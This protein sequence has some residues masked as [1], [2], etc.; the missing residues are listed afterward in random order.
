MDAWG[1]VRARLLSYLRA[2]RGRCR[3]P[4]RLPDRP[5]DPVRP[6]GNP[7]GQTPMEF[8][9]RLV[10][11]P[12]AG[13]ETQGA[14]PRVFKR[15]AL[16]P[17]LRPLRPGQPQRAPQPSK[18]PD[19]RPSRLLP[20]DPTPAVSI[21]TE[22]GAYEE[23]ECD[24]PFRANK[25]TA[26]SSQPPD[27]NSNQVRKALLPPPLKPQL[28]SPAPSPARKRSTFDPGAPPS[29]SPPRHPDYSVPL[30]GAADRPLGSNQ[31]TDAEY[32]YT[33]PEGTGRTLPCPETPALGGLKS[34][35]STRG[36][37]PPPPPPPPPPPLPAR[38]SFMTRIPLYLPVLP[39]LPDK[40]TSATA[41]TGPPDKEQLPGNP[42]VILV[43]VGRLVAQDDDDD[44]DDGVLLVP[45][46][47]I[48]C[49]GCGAASEA[50]YYD[51]TVGPCCP[52]CTA[53]DP[54]WRPAPCLPHPQGPEH[55]L[56]LLPP[57]PPPP[58][59]LRDPLVIFCVD[60]SGSMS[61]TTEVEDCGQIHY[62][63]RLQV[64]Q[65]GV[66]SSLHFLHARAPLTRVGLITFNN[67]V[68][69]HG[70]GGVARRSL[71]GE[72]LVDTE[73]LRA[74]GAELPM[75]RPLAASR[76]W[77]ETVLHRLVESGATALGPAVLVAITMAS[78]QPGSKVILCTDGKA[79]TELGDLE[80]SDPHGL[81]PS[82]LFYEALGREAQSSGVIVSVLAI[83]G[84]D[85]RLA[86]LGRLADMSGGKVNSVNPE[87]L[88]AEFQRVLQDQAIATHVSVKLILPTALCLKGEAEESHTVQ[89]EVGSISRD[90]EV[91]FQFR[92]R[93][94]DRQ[95]VLSQG[96]VSVQLQVRFRQLDGQR[97]LR[98]ESVEREVTEDSSL[99]LSSLSV[100]VLQVHLAQNS[101]ALVVRGRWR[102][103]QADADEQRR[104]IER[105][106][107]HLKCPEQRER[108][109]RWVKTISP[110][111]STRDDSAQAVTDKGASLLYELKNTHRTS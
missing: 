63:S 38:P 48:F 36:C 69:V 24:L 51:N 66:I 94:P 41:S 74:V 77:L 19:D 7:G 61:I 71:R 50:G 107:D 75:P 52:F 21:L 83:E 9:S 87:N 109:E 29:S 23:I 15:S 18:T 11:L 92:V 84:T 100:P 101:A 82:S 32:S 14:G 26:V 97:R 10:Y 106:L 95:A 35:V 47:P 55:H 1:G 37:L 6:A 73:A 3:R 49:G 81:V 85:C 98:V 16:L 104:L 103:A 93:E 4:E 90:T 68:T 27:R 64:V 40:N 5:V 59:G 78:R 28:Q 13:T 34:P 105:A 67:E 79:N 44:D 53:W 57:G 46:E 65:E 45:A 8:A 72:E 33:I 43:G 76:D 22:E 31:D 89:R 70:D 56:Y 25:A 39:A 110:I 88:S 91:T 80:L 30:D 102:Q 2:R 108:H 20:T 86:E 12:P 60:V 62:K 99:V 58:T 17:P 42:N 96:R 54:A 111:Y